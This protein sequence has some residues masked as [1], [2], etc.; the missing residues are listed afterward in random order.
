MAVQ[1][2]GLAIGGWVWLRGLDLDVDVGMGVGVAVTVPKA[3]LPKGNGRVAY[4]RG[5]VNGN[6]ADLIPKTVALTWCALGKGAPSPQRPVSSRCVLYPVH[7]SLG[8]SSVC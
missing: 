7:G 6:A 8:D 2:M 5:Q 3:L 4:P 1:R